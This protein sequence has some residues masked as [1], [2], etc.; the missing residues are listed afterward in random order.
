VQTPPLSG[1]LSLLFV[2]KQQ[3]VS[4]GCPFRFLLT[5]TTPKM[6]VKLCGLQKYWVNLQQ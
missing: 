3:S 2:K 1:V 4:G 5:A 6:N